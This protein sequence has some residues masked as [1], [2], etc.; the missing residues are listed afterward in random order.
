[1]GPRKSVR[2]SL[3]RCS[4]SLSLALRGESLRPSALPGNR[5]DECLP[6]RVSRVREAHAGG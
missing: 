2:C 4:Q 5:S 1:M 6:E 3:I